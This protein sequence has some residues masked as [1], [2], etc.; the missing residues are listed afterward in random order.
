M[1]FHRSR[2]LALLLLIS[3]AA[4]L[5]ASPGLAAQAPAV[6]VLRLATTTSTADTGLLATL[7]PDFERQCRCRVDVVAVGTGQAI[8]L[9]RRGD[10]DVLLVHARDQEDVF[11]ADGHAARRDDVMY[12]DFIIVGPATDPAGIARLKTAG[13]AFKAIAQTGSPFASRGDKSG[14]HAKE[15]A[16]WGPGSAPDARATWYLSVGQGMGETLTFANERRAYTLSDRATWL[17]TRTKL[18]GLRLLFGGGTL[19]DNPDRGLR[20][21]YGVMAVDGAKHPGGRATLA[22]QFVDWILSKPTQDR[23]GSFGLDTFGQ[24]LFYP[25][26][27]AR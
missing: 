12:N 2:L 16:I 9:G 23:I 22:R 11:V 18:P 4:S 24:R 5:A 19:A 26:A 13:D 6:G 8:E 20:N 1:V 10:V 21:N 15:L 27:A 14:T 25:N 3:S 17:A 7:L